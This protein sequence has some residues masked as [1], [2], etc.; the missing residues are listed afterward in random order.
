MPPER[1]RALKAWKIAQLA[2]LVVTMPALAGQIE[3]RDGPVP[4]VSIG[5]RIDR[6]DEVVFDHIVA[7]VTNALVVLTGP[8][9]D[10]ASALAIGQQVR[11]RGWQ[12]LVPAGSFCASACALIWLAGTQ[13]M[14][15]VNARIGFHAISVRN[16]EGTAVETH[17]IDPALVNYLMRLG[18]AFD[19]TATIVNTPSR[20]VRW[21]DGL[22]LNAN[23]IATASYPQPEH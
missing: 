9:G 6:G 4:M 17:E 1:R 3:I 19:V 23:G 15:G 5:G 22:E 21:L 13:R 20:M 7:H 8:G 12:T 11:A 16:N 18:Y 2:Y 14:L 10:V